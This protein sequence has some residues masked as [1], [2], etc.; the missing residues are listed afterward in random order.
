MCIIFIAFEAR[1]DYPLI[2]AAN[3]DE[4]YNRPSAAAGWWDDTPG[5]FAGR[6]LVGWGTWL[7]VTRSGRFAAVTN[8]RD[9]AGNIGTVSRG[10]LVANFL[11]GNSLAREYLE[12]VKTHADEFSGFNLLVGEMTKRRRELFYYSNRG[13]E[14]MKL[15][16]G[17][18]G[19][20]NHL[21]DTPWPK[22]AIGKQE[23]EGLI[24]RSELDKEGLFRLLADSALA[25]DETLPD[26]GVGLEIERV[27]SAIFIKTAD[28]GTR[29]STVLTFDRELKFELN[30]RV[31]V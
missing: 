29:C 28:Y 2:L 30:E 17:I 25:P 6:D 4:F 5:I 26:T 13:N 20:S 12:D 1:A 8:Y 15:G 11:K 31:F 9:P 24:G 3:R 16:T 23:F 22:V 21:L 7:G 10:D 14:I 27:L 18:Y 19:L